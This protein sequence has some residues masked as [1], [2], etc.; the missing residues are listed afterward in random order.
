MLTKWRDQQKER[1][2]VRVLRTVIN[3]RNPALKGAIYGIT[4]RENN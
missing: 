2:T 3:K 4:V 1:A